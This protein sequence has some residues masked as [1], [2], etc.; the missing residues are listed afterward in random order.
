MLEFASPPAPIAVAMRAVA[1]DSISQARLIP[2]LLTSGRAKHLVVEG[3]D[4]M[5]HFPFT[6]DAN[7]P[8]IQALLP[9]V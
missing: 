1:S 4:C 5:F 8:L 7:P 2:D 6:H 9:S 3:H